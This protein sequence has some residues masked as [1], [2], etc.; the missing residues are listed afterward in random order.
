MFKTHTIAKRLFFST[1]LIMLTTIV[2]TV[3]FG[4]SLMERYY[5]HN[6]TAELKQTYQSFTAALTQNENVEDA[7]QPIS[8]VLYDLEKRNIN[9]M[10]FTIESDGSISQIIVN[11]RYNDWYNK[12]NSPI[13]DYLKPEFDPVF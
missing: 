1:I 9:A 5:L 4:S 11:S 10:L 2:S 12:Q 7:L 8:D 6:K 13:F 3:L